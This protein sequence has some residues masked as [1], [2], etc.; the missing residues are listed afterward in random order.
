ME[1][2]EYI[3]VHDQQVAMVYEI[4]VTYSKL[5]VDPRRADDA[6]PM[7]SSRFMLRPTWTISAL[8]HK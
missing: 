5:D 3:L 8:W 6:S 7:S 2:M 4:T 1:E